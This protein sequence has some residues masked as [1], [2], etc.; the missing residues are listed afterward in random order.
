MAS[1]LCTLKRN[2][3]E[4]EI[5][6]TKF[7]T[8]QHC[9]VFQ[10]D[11]L[12]LSFFASEEHG[13]LLHDC[14]PRPPTYQNLLG[15]EVPHYYFTKKVGIPNTCTVI[16]CSSFALG[17][18]NCSFTLGSIVTWE[19]LAVVTVETATAFSCFLFFFF[20][21]AG[22]KL[23]TSHMLGRCSSTQSNYTWGTFSTQ[24]PSGL[25]GSK[26]GGRGWSCQWA[27]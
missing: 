1:W 4:I 15:M 25:V 13:F 14:F 16:P 23:K 21:S 27:P 19:A 3:E 5:Y 9:C 11:V 24:D 26:P 6:I 8:K 20:F 12:I 2:W 17:S 18:N 22:V 10:E 7:K